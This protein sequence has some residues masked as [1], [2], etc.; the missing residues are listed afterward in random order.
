MRFLKGRKPKEGLFGLQEEAE[1]LN[2]AVKK[3]RKAGSNRRDRRGKRISVLYLLPSIL[4]VLLFF[5]LPFLIVI[6]Y[7]VIDNPIS[8]EFVFFDNFVMVFQNAAFRQA[9][10]NTLMFSA[11]AVPLAVVLSM[12]LAM[13]LESKIPFKSQF[14]TFFLSPM[15]VPIASVVL[16]WQVL[17]HYNGM[18]NE[19]L[20]WFGKDKIDWLNSAYAQVVIVVLFLWKNLGYNM[21][22]F[23]AALGSIPKDILEVAVL[24][25]A[26]PFQIF[27]HIK[28]RYMSSTILFVTIMSLINSFKVF[29]EIYLLK[30]DYPYDTMYMLQHFMNNTFGK[31]DYQKMSAAAIMM[32][33]VMVV[34]IGILFV[35]E[36]YFGKDVEG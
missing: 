16:I 7:S 29:R 2:K 24:E 30:G 12:L 35:T 14:R 18:M 6:Y 34:I 1:E 15:M 26:S 27:W 5:V 36:S 10:K 8:G 9:A 32:A 33:I 21:I 31:L 13:M 22:L 17:F 28:L 3:G 23:M 20:G 19:I 4:G 25:S 11:T